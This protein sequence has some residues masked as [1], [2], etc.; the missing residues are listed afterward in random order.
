VHPRPRSRS[1]SHSPE[2]SPEPEPSA[3]SPAPPSDARDSR[4]PPPMSLVLGALVA[5]NANGG[6]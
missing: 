5:P 2:S 6:K 4:T 3:S 1:H